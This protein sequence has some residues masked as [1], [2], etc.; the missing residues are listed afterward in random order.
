MYCRR[1]PIVVLAQL[2]QPHTSLVTVVSTRHNARAG[3]EFSQN[4]PKCD[5]SLQRFTRPG[6]RRLLSGR[7]FPSLGPYQLG[8]MLWCEQGTH[9]FKVKIKSRKMGVNLWLRS[10]RA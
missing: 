1:L 7:L 2:F 6:E 4:S 10:E 3:L 5:S 8:V 9:Y